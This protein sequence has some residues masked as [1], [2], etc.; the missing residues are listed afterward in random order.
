MEQIAFLNDDQADGNGLADMT[1]IS[2]VAR[3]G[4]EP[5]NQLTAL[6]QF[7]GV[8]RL[9]HLSV[10]QNANRANDKDKFQFIS[11]CASCIG[12]GFSSLFPDASGDGIYQ[13]PLPE[14]W[15]A[16]VNKLTTTSNR[17]QR[18]FVLSSIL[19]LVRIS[20]R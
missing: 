10:A 7:L 18:G 5:Q 2:A 20:L 11:V 6:R 14:V 9:L 3:M 16:V 8:N 15:A 4:N 1:S 13:L 19:R 12:P 17:L